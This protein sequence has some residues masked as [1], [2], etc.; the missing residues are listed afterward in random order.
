MKPTPKLLLITSLFVVFVGCTDFA[1]N[2]QQAEQ[3]R[4]QQTADELR[5]LGKAMHEQPSDETGPHSTVAHDPDSIDTSNA[6]KPTQIRSGDNMETVLRTLLEW[7]AIEYEFARYSVLVPFEGEATRDYQ[8]RWQRELSER[9]AR[10]KEPNANLQGFELPNGLVITLCCSGGTLDSITEELPGDA[11]D[12]AT[13]IQGF[14]GL[15]YDGDWK[16]IPDAA[17]SQSKD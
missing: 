11:K 8:R 9:G 12:T 7:N 1:S 5:D 13:S 6:P 15:R 14:A 3:D 10:P 16:L 2:Q 17:H 4:Q